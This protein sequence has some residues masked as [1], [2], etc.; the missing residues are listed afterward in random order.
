MSRVAPPSRPANR[1]GSRWNEK[2]W[3]RAP[4][5][6]TT[7]APFRAWRGSSALRRPEPKLVYHKSK[8]ANDVAHFSL[9][10]S[11]P[12]KLIGGEGGIRTLG[13][14]RY[15]RFPIVLLRPLGH[16]SNKLVRRHQPRLPLLCSDSVGGRGW[17]GGFGPRAQFRRSCF[18]CSR[19]ERE[20]RL[21]G[22]FEHGAQTRSDSGEGGIRTPGTL[23]GTPDFESGAIDRTLPPLQVVRT[24]NTASK[25]YEN[26]LDRLRNWAKKSVS[27]APHSAANALCST[28]T[29]WFK[30]GSSKRR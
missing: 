29:W 9:R 14:L 1:S 28:T 24:Q 10:P 21:R 7:V 27:R 8:A 22:L 3:L 23:A 15:T 12:L 19:S 17:S 26:Q 25:P 5:P 13:T 11:D 2:R 6:L 20:K 30:R 16:L 4:A 18:S